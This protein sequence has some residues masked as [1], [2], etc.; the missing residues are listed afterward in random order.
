MIL[1]SLYKDL[2][3][4]FISLLL[5]LSS[6]SGITEWRNLY[7]A[8]SYKTSSKR[9]YRDIKSVIKAVCREV[10]GFYNNDGGSKRYYNSLDLLREGADYK[11]NHMYKSYKAYNNNSTGLLY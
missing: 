10:N 3:R 11:G 7:T 4:K 5:Y 9:L 8:L 1:I 2:F 6:F